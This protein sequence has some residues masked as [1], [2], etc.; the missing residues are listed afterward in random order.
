MSM[1]PSFVEPSAPVLLDLTDAPVLLQDHTHE[2]HLIHVTNDKT[3][4]LTDKQKNIVAV[5]DASGEHQPKALNG[6]N[7]IPGKYGLKGRN[8]RDAL[9][10]GQN[11]ENGENGT[12]GDDGENG[13]DAN[14]GT[15]GTC[16]R[17]L[18]VD[19]SGFPDTLKVFISFHNFF[20]CHYLGPRTYI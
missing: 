14:H 12:D 17:N 20:Y 19:I 6:R 5:I 9:Y 3:R 13:T 8:G 11:G 15:N 1:N 4:S 7:G 18:F 10:P 2:Q 16:A